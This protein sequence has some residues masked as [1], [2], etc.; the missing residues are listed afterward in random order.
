MS[1]SSA[2]DEPARVVGV[3]GAREARLHVTGDADG[4][5]LVVVRLTAELHEAGGGEDRLDPRDVV[6]ASAAAADS[7][8]TKRRRGG[9]LHRRVIGSAEDPV[10]QLV[11][12]RVEH[13]RERR[14]VPE[15]EHEQDEDAVRPEPVP[16]AGA[17]RSGSTRSSSAE[18]SSGGIGSRLNRPRNR[19]TTAKENRTLDAERQ[20]L[21]ERGTG[22]DALVQRRAPRARR[23]ASATR[24]VAG[25]ARLT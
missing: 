15:H 13:L 21:V 19:F 23:S 5:A 11:D 18:P 2:A 8:R 17:T 10:E 24:L 14:P 1:C 6:G 16:A 7:A 3:L 9:E 25:P 22:S 20:L 12:E 4:V